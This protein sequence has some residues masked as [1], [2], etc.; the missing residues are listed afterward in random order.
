MRKTLIALAVT[1]LV[2][3]C[4]PAQE[5]ATETTPA[6]STAA[7]ESTT[8]AAQS[9]SERLNQ[10]FETK[11]EEQLQM[12]PL[13][14]TFLGRKDKNDQI[15]EVTEAAED[16]QLAWHAATVEELKSQFDYSK[17]DMEAKTSYDLWIYQY[18]Q[19]RDAAAFRVNTYVFNQMQGV[20]ALLP[21]IMINFHKV[22]EVADM[23]AYIKRL[24][25]IAK[26]IAELQ[27]RAAK[28]AEAGVRPPR[29]AYEGVIEQVNNLLTGAP[30]TDSDKDAPLWADAKSKIDSLKKAD[31]LDDKK[32]EQLLADVKSALTTQFQPSYQA[33]SAFLTSELDKTTVNPT[34]VS[35]Q[36]NGVAYYN[37]RLKNS[38]TTSLTAE[39]IHQIGLNEVDRITKEMIAIKDQVGFKGDLQEF[40]KFIKTDSQFFYPDTDEGR[41]SYLKDSEAYLAFIEKKLP[42]YF[43]ILPK[44]PLVVKRVEAFREQPGAA[45]HYF[46][47]TP[48]GKR[49]GI[50]YAHLS[51]MKQMPKNEMEAIAYHEGSPGHHMQISIAQE[52]KSVPT[53][54]TQAGFTAYVEG[55]ALYSEVLAKEMGAYQSPYT[56]FGRLI[57]E[58]WR[59]VRLVVDTGMHAKGWTEQQAIDYFKAKTPVAEGAVVSEVR[60]YLVW[61]GQAT[62]YKI[63]MLKIQELRAKAKEQLGDKFDIRGFHDTVLGGGALPLDVLEKRVQNWVDSVKSV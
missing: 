18:E 62:A 20:H 10:W 9:E 39:E 28:Y 15:D 45:Q 63:G 54:R 12:S 60:R 13:Q 17:L 46:P 36:P 48:D 56:D 47:G 16:Q 30:F 21:Q 26:A 38:T 29:F 1:A 59:A 37:H 35:T 5:K 49:P 7:A 44:A 42:E 61:P 31:K 50:Y 6:A 53:F 58:M 27:Q 32:A 23:E 34:G 19:A 57:T 43:G 51:D 41:N 11:Y 8:A 55:W 4:N 33:L 24:G 3:G 2:S 25:G 52:L 40:F 14:M 22:D